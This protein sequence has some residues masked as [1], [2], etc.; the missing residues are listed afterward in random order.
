LYCYPCHSGIDENALY[1]WFNAK[2]LA[3]IDES[4]HPDQSTGYRRQGYENLY[5]IIV[6]RT[7][8]RNLE[9]MTAEIDAYIQFSH[10]GVPVS[11]TLATD[12]MQNALFTNMTENIYTP[13]HYDDLM[14]FVKVWASTNQWMR[15]GTIPIHED[16]LYGNLKR[17]L[18]NV[19]LPHKKHEPD[20]DLKHLRELVAPPTPVSFPFYK[21]T[22]YGLLCTNPE[23]DTIHFQTMGLVLPSMSCVVIARVI[24][25]VVYADVYSSGSVGGSAVVLYPSAPFESINVN[26]NSFRSVIHGRQTLFMNSTEQTVFRID[27]GKVTDMIDQDYTC[28]SITPDPPKTTM[29]NHRIELDFHPTHWKSEISETPVITPVV[30]VPDMVPIVPDIQF[31][32]EMMLQ[33]MNDMSMIEFMSDDTNQTLKRYFRQR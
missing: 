28:T 31:L 26:V 10:K 24:D 18:D 8:E 13:S 3:N 20:N 12:V 30:T 21:K 9:K 16:V 1:K 15:F 19:K 5:N 32:R 4:G 6:S 11:V 7:A 23:N 17:P 33:C 14:G 2:E 25:S 29:P 22:S 27:S